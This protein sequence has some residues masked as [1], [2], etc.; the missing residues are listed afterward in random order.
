MKRKKKARKKK[1]ANNPK[2]P[3]KPIFT[4]FK[5]I[6]RIGRDGKLKGKTK[7]FTTGKY[8]YLK[9][10]KN[11]DDLRNTRKRLR[12]LGSDVRM[13]RGNNKGEPVIR[14]WEK[15]SMFSESTKLDE[16]MI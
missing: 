1:K 9:S 11:I 14:L 4:E 13:S 5:M 7:R 10:F 15:K 3:L 2:Q 6:K 12:G 16:N 8:T